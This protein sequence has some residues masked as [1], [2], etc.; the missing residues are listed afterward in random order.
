MEAL[1]KGLS[2]CLGCHRVRWFYLGVPSELLRKMSRRG[3]AS[4]SYRIDTPA[5]GNTLQLVLASVLE[6]EG[7]TQQREVQQMRNAIIGGAAVVV[8]LTLVTPQATAMPAI[9]LVKDIV[10]GEEGSGPSELVS[11]G[12]SVYFTARDPGSGLELW[13]SD[14]TDVGTRMV[15]DIWPGPGSSSPR[16]LTNFG[17]NV[18][19]CSHRWKERAWPRAME[20]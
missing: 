3:S 17:G 1:V 18:V 14:G 4:S 13:K 7:Q 2:C 11:V 6:S 16:Q 9:H 5:V 8:A 15:R 10:P 20:V 12:S 19:L